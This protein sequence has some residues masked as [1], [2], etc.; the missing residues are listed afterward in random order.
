M[1]GRLAVGIDAGGTK[2]LGLLVGKN[3]EVLDRRHIETPATD[4]EASAAAVVR[5]ARA[6]TS[7]HRDL[8][9]VGVGAAGIVDRDGRMR[10]APNVAWRELAL[11]ERV[12]AEVP[13]PVL[14]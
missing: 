11:R 7:D 12:A 1:T 6:L 4:A 9:A 5:L 13:V 3:G 14:V 10:F 8:V 2:V